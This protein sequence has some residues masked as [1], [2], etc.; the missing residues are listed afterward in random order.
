[1][2]ITAQMMICK[3][4]HTWYLKDYTLDIDESVIDVDAEIG[5]VATLLAIKDFETDESVELIALYSHWDEEP[6]D[7]SFTVYL[8]DA[9]DA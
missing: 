7:G 1:M 2:K 5:K 3:R 9:H 8:E 4:D 6:D